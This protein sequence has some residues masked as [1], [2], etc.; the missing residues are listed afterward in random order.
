MGKGEAGDYINTDD[1]PFP[2]PRSP[3]PV[4]IR[5]AFVKSATR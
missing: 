3:F 2:V 5:P 1:Y 4:L